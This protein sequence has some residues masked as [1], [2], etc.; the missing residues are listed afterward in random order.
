[1][2]IR[3]YVGVCVCVTRKKLHVWW[4]SVSLVLQKYAG[5][6]LFLFRYWAF[7]LYGCDLLR[8]K[9]PQPLCPCRIVEIRLD[10]RECG[11]RRPYGNNFI[12]SPLGSES[13]TQGT[14]LGK[15]F[16][17]EH[18]KNRIIHSEVCIK[19]FAGILH[20]GKIALGSSLPHGEFFQSTRLISGSIQKIMG[21]IS[22]PINLSIF[23]NDC[24]SAL[25]L[26]FS[27]NLIRLL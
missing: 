2:L 6:Q 26:C 9:Q 20:G 15:S 11:S 1:M 27:W 8:K 19:G 18:V 13:K 3:I 22:P 17:N 10:V 14:K 12:R 25:S 21:A 7:Y 4:T 24:A 23:I 16:Q 5:L